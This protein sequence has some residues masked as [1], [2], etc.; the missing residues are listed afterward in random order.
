MNFPFDKA[1]DRLNAECATQADV[2][3]WL[4]YM[5]KRRLA[6]KISAAK[7]QSEREWAVSKLV[8]SEARAAYRRAQEN[9]CR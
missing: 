8:A 6:G 4:T 1:F 2:D 9:I 3:C 7:L 5:V